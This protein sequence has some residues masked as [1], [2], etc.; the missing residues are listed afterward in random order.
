MNTVAAEAMIT[1][2][3][4]EVR[5]LVVGSRQVTLS[6]AKQLDVV[7]LADLT[8]M[9]RVR[10]SSDYTY[11]IGTAGDGSLAVARYQK[12]WF[13]GPRYI[14]ADDLTGKVTVC[15]RLSSDVRGD[16]HLDVQGVGF[17]LDSSAAQHCTIPGHERWRNPRQE[18]DG[19]TAP[20]EVMIQIKAAVG[21]KLRDEIATAARNK[22][23]AAAPLIVLA[24]LK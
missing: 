1:T 9:G 24:G 5:T 12:P 11:V 3:T 16:Y 18:C 19:W 23:A 2:L 21:T 17:R 13:P 15:Q 20:P 4:A 7:P 8:V 6:V 22:S 14:N 10:I